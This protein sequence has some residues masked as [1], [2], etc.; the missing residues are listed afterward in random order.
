MYR[1]YEGCTGFYT[2]FIGSLKQW[3]LYGFYTGFVRDPYGIK[4][5]YD[6]FMKAA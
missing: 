2:G 4:V 1:V 6:D 5:F 3:V